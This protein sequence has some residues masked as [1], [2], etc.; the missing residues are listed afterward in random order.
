MTCKKN[1][2]ANMSEPVK[3]FLAR[4]QWQDIT[5]ECVSDI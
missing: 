5:S 2:S 4:A 3:W 1:V